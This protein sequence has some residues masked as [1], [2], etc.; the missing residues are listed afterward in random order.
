MFP[1]F[2]FS[3]AHVMRNFQPSP[4]LDTTAIHSTDKTYF[5]VTNFVGH[6]S[7]GFQSTENSQG[8][9]AQ[10]CGMFDIVRWKGKNKNNK[11]DVG[12]HSITFFSSIEVNANIYN[13]IAFNPRGIILQESFAYFNKRK[14]FT[15][16]IGFT[17]KSRHE[18]DSD[19]PPNDTTSRIGYQPTSRVAILNGPHIEI[20]SDKINL[21]PTIT[22][23]IWG[24][25]EYYTIS[26]DSRFPLISE[27]QSWDYMTG[28]VLLGGRID[29]KLSKKEKNVWGFY[30]RSW[31]NTAIF[32][33]KVK[34]EG[35]KN[36]KFNYRIESGFDFRGL[37][38]KADFFVAREHFFDDL[39]SPRPI[40]SSVWLIGIRG[41]GFLFL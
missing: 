9:N 12:L 20:L 22:T 35:G 34:E 28:M 24:R 14:N 39:S 37:K 21:S 7:R 2:A 4:F 38:G 23:N 30:N 19:S 15:W 13:N 29:I 32:S 6:T 41:R 26:E 31:V 17:H 5:A 3:Q 40:S 25:A 18:I 27:E 33:N 11:N 8:W 1:F 36:F 10:V 16:N